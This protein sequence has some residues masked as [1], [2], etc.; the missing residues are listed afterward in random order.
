MTTAVP[1]SP[2]GSS[3]VE[4]AMRGVRSHIRDHDLKVGDALPGEA[5]FASHF[6]VS[7]A[8]MRE[9]FGALAALRLIDVAN[10]RRARVSAIDGTVLAT[11]LDHAVATDQISVP[12]IWEVRRTLELRT[13]ELAARYRSDDAAAEILAAADDMIAGR[14]RLDVVTRADIRFHQRIALASGNALYHQI[15][16]SFAPLMAVAVPAAWHTRT[17]GAQREEILTRHRSIAEAIA[18]RSPEAA[19]AAM[20]GHFDTDIA[21]V[22]AAAKPET[23]A[24]PAPKGR[25]ATQA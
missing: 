14:D 3:L 6:G 23:G 4:I 1:E 16:R 8:V 2:P 25:L 17:T 9:A 22:F 21:E 11:S 15:I 18:D 12:E 13:A 10:G 19:V 7:K 20:N 24:F 5:T